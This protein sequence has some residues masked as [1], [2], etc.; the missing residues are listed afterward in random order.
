MAAAPYSRREPSLPQG[1]PSVDSIRPPTEQAAPAKTVSFELLFP[2]PHSRVRLPLRVSVFPH[3]T[4]E[5][6]VI[7]VR[8]FYGLYSSA[9][10]FK[11][12]SFEDAQG[13]TLIAR[14]EN[15]TDQMTV[16]VRVFE[17]EPSPG[18]YQS[19]EYQQAV[20]NGDSYPSHAPLPFSEHIA[21][22]TS[23]TA[24]RRSPSPCNQ[25]RRSASAGKFRSNASSARGSA[26]QEGFDHQG[27]AMNGYTSGDG[28]PGS[29]SSKNKD[30]LGNTDISLDNIVEGHRRKRAKFESSVRGHRVK[31]ATLCHDANPLSTSI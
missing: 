5:S 30:H 19:S 2:D 13:R 24:G 4:T 9:T 8:N 11:G 25:Q 3:D 31:A 23:R 29:S 1:H 22:A 26:Y 14:Y 27:D 6:I 10:V 15:F 28:A 21:R 18:T 12:V 16:Y 20:V 7:T 17:G